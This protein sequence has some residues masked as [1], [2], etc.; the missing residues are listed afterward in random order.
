MRSDRFPEHTDNVAFNR[1]FWD[2]YAADWDD[3]RVRHAGSDV[4]AEGEIDPDALQV[5]GD[6]WGLPEEVA[7]VVDDYILPFVGEE[8][9][10][11][12]IG[13]GGGRVALRVADKVREFHG[14]DVAPGMLDRA[15]HTVGHRDNVHLKLVDG[16][17]IPVADGVFD[18]VYS[19]D[20]FVHLDLHTQW[21]YLQEISRVLKP[22]ARAFLH[23]ANLTTGEGW[24]LFSSQGR[25]D[26]TGFYF[27]TPE[28]VDTL[29]AHTDLGIVKRS[30]P[31][32]PN[33]YI[34]R[35]YLFVLEKAG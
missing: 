12:E 25:F 30:E 28:M 23:T 27:L 10:I 34:D 18:F 2:R 8:S 20:V 5:V 9:V 21:A 22:G 6:E 33:Y 24:K 3:P 7:E 13:C 26:V 35:D 32:S 29:L 14:F 31:G 17:H 15:R 19:F 11:A 16:T 1:Q 4:R